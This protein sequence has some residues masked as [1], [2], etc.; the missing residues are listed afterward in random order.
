MPAAMTNGSGSLYQ[1]SGGGTNMRYHS[2][3]LPIT[4][5]A[6][7]GYV[8]SL[9]TAM[10]PPPGA[11]SSTA[12]KQCFFRYCHLLLGSTRQLGSEMSPS[13]TVAQLYRLCEDLGVA[14]DMTG[15]IPRDSITPGRCRSNPT[16]LC[17]SVS[18]A[19]YKS[20]NEAAVSL[21]SWLHAASGHIDDC[22]KRPL[23][24]RS[25]DETADRP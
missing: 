9:G 20:S 1:V 2:S 19:R 15:Q 13:M 4:G 8:R 12:L 14:G 10:Q 23:F 7:G 22:G 6:G 3:D 5:M 21:H 16:C 25:A 17:R 11:E 24:M 18:C